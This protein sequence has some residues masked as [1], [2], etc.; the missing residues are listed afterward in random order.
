MGLNGAPVCARLAA[1]SQPA[2]EPTCHSIKNYFSFGIPARPSVL[3]WL[4]PASSAACSWLRS[5]SFQVYRLWASPICPSRGRDQTLNSLDGNV[6]CEA[7]LCE[8]I[9]IGNT[10]FGIPD[11]IGPTGFLFQG[12]QDLK[13]VLQFI[14][15]TPSDSD[16]GVLARKRIIHNYPRSTRK[17]AFE[18]FLERQKR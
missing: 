1:Q 3:A 6:L 4:A 18:N 14:K 12:A 9:P 2:G 10:V 17:R 11:V 7:M 16:L 15:T 13:A 5:A 8:C